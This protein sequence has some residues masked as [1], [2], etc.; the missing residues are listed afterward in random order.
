MPEGDTVY[1]QAAQLHSALAGKMLLRSDFRVPSYAVLDLACQRIHEVVPR[2]KHLLIRVGEVTIHS[3]LKMEGTWDVYAHQPGAKAS[4]R[5]P[6]H[7]A[8]CVLVTDTV[9]AV[10]FS[11]GELDVL[12]TADEAK[13]VGHL[14]PDLLGPDWDQN[15]TLEN[16]MAVPDRALGM[17]LLDQRNL[18]GIGNI[19]RSEVCFLARVHPA[20]K[21][22][23]VPDLPVVLTLAKKLLEVNK[24]R[25]GRSTTGMPAGP[26]NAFWVYGR[27][28]KACR[29]CHSRIVRD[30]LGEEAL[31]K[32]GMTD[33]SIYFCPQ[34]QPDKSA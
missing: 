3:H 27:E 26:N 13:I 25:A 2:G 9:T 34:C 4:W 30:Y 33:R 22:G 6:G 31:R 15:K 23:D 11:L 28:G 17:A 18:A 5:R 12:K 21:V 19:F 16:I 29:R 14:G 7:T 20:T 1:R 24:L 8:R 32:V 10:G